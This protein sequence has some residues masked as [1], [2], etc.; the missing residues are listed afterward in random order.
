VN[1]L[2]TICRQF[3]PCSLLSMC[4]KIVVPVLADFPRSNDRNGDPKLTNMDY[5]LSLMPPVD[6][7]RMANCVLRAYVSYCF[8]LYRSR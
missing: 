7:L 3:L 6:R 2:A 1:P 5:R 8:W 4:T